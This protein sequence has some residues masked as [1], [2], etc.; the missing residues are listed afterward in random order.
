MSSITLSKSV[1]SDNEE[2]QSHSE[3]EIDTD[4]PLLPQEDSPLLLTEHYHSNK[5][6][7]LPLRATVLC[8]K[9]PPMW[10]RI[11]WSQFT[12]ERLKIGVVLLFVLM[13]AGMFAFSEEEDAEL[14]SL[15]GISYDYPLVCIYLFIYF[16]FNFSLLFITH[17][18]FFCLDN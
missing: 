18:N 12:L 2:M 8:W 3:F 16:F 9:D 1:R 5:T 4:E 7:E 17:K 11:I 13:A 6:V 14:L 10:A 15:S